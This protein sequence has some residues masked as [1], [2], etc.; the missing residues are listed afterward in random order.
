M[1]NSKVPNACQ[2]C[3]RQKLKCD[4]NRPCTL[5]ERAGITCQPCPD[6][7]W[8]VYQQPRSTIAERSSKRSRK[9]F[10]DDQTQLTPPE[11]GEIAASAEPVTSSSMI[12]SS[13]N[14]SSTMSLVDGAFLLH[15][16]SSISATNAIPGGSP[17]WD[18][19]REECT[20]ATA[21]SA[22]RPKPLRA[23]ASNM[24]PLAHSSRSV[25]S[26]L[27]ELLPDYNAAA[28]L[29]DTYFDRVHWFMLIFHQDEFRRRWP[30]LYASSGSL[31]RSPIDNNAFMSTFLMV[32]GIGLQYIGDHRRR[33]LLDMGIKPEPLK[34]RILSS[35][36]TKLLDIVS[37]GSLEAVQTCILLGTYYLYHGTPRLASPVCGCGLRVAQALNLHRRMKS[38]LFNSAG[39]SG[40]FR[41]MNEARKRSWWAIYEIETF[42]SMTYGYPHSIK[43]SDYDVEPL[44]PSA[45]EERSHPPTSFDEPLRCDVTLLSYKYY[46]SKLS[47]LTKEAL[48]ELYGIGG[49][50]EETKV[51]HSSTNLQGIIPK[52][53]GLDT[54]LLNWHSELPTKL[55][56]GQ[57]RDRTMAY[58]SADELDHD[59]G[60]AGPRFENHIFE[61]QALA[62]KLAYE[63]ARILVHRPLLSYK[64]VSASPSSSQSNP[65]GMF[66]ADPFHNSLEI[67]RQ[68][69]LQISE[70]IHSP[71]VDL[72]SATY[73]AAFVSIH[74][75]AAGVLLAILSSM[76]PLSPQSLEA[77]VGLHQIMGIQE[78]L[79][80]RCV[81]AAQGLEILKR[82]TKLV[83]E[84]E[85]NTMLDLSEPSQSLRES[86]IQSHVV[87]GADHS[88]AENMPTQNGPDDP[89][90]RSGRR[91]NLTWNAESHLPS[92]TSLPGDIASHIDEPGSSFQYIEDTALSDALYDFD[93]ALLTCAPPST[94]SRHGVSSAHLAHEGFPML[95]QTWIW[96]LDNA[97]LFEGPMLNE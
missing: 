5:C 51:L 80:T 52:V 78:K 2:R 56:W 87:S 95:E 43:D 13:W 97:S 34:Q 74:T 14:S 73:A 30:T 62:L 49:P 47:V 81:L 57:I 70:L 59:I 54:R 65:S 25:V 27:A 15:N 10:P 40:H 90:L 38:Q 94:F 89:R 84:K 55:E 9:N 67:C 3:R 68:S 6:S 71:M 36:K 77:K 93:Q 60:A 79:K 75:F 61:L 19:V 64:L 92:N 11:G 17:E 12:D 22:S 35:I 42:S 28:L 18:S 72:V 96:G 46:M 29:V 16:S 85:L 50:A 33:R 76:S 69:A 58:S 32:I 1:V 82:L 26:E 23:S 20:R 83:M 45:K 21:A 31:P 88:S 39:P 44:D 37:L 63:N 91:E 8:R 53:T 41:I 48:S 4:I 7:R 24:R 86:Q 66:P